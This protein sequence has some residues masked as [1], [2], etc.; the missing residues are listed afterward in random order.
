MLRAQ[1]FRTIVKSIAVFSFFVSCSVSAY[2]QVIISFRAP[3]DKEFSRPP[4]GY[5]KCH[6]IPSGFYN[7]IWINKHRVC[8][9]QG[10][11][12]NHGRNGKWV[13]GYWRCD[14]YKPKHNHCDRWTWV[15]SHWETRH[16]VSYGRPTRQ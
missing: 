13:S 2:T 10:N 6:I 3:A 1:F 16:F 5:V 8:D 12:N 9:Y 4:E 14:F 11:H 7:G 15:P